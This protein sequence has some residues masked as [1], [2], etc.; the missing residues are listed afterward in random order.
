MEEPQFI[1]RGGSD[2]GFSGASDHY[3]RGTLPINKL[4][5]MNMGS[6]DQQ[7]LQCVFSRKRF[8]CEESMDPPLSRISKEY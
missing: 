7:L 3:W 5:L 2:S 1:D 6:T 8:G 4:G